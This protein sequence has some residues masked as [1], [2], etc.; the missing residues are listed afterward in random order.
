[1]RLCP[2]FATPPSRQNGQRLKPYFVLRTI[3]LETAVSARNT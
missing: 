3:R 1:L 2:A